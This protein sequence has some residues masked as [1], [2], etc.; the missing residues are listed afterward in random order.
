MDTEM[1]QAREN[2]METIQA[3]LKEYDHIPPEEKCM[4][5]LLAEERFL[6]IKQ[7][8]EEEQNQPE[9]MQEL[10]LKL[11]KDL[12]ILNGIQTK[13]E[14]LAEQEEPAVPKSKTLCLNDNSSAIFESMPLRI[15]FLNFFNDPKIIREQRNA[16]YKG[17]RGGVTMTKVIKGEFEKLESLKISDVSLTC[18]TSL[19]IF[20]KEFNRMSRMDD[21]LFTYEVEIAKTMDHYT[22]KELWMYWARGDD[23]FEI[24]DKESSTSEDEDEVAENFWIETNLFDF[25]TPLCK[26]FKKFNYLL[27]INPD[28]LTEDIEGFKT[29]KYYK[30][31]WISLK[32]GKLKEE[33]L[34]NKAIME[35]IIEYEDNESS[36]EGWRRW[37]IYEN[38]NHGPEEREYDMEH[39]NKERCELFDDQERPFPVFTAGVPVRL[40]ALAMAAVC[41]SRAAV[42][43]AV[44]YRMASK[45][46]AGVSDVDLIDEMNY[47][48]V[49]EEDGEWIRFLGGSS[50]SGTKK[51]QRLNS[52]DGGNTGDGVKIAGGVIGSG[53]EIEF[54]EELKV[55][56]LDATLEIIRMKTQSI[57]KNIHRGK[58]ILK[59]RSRL[60]EDIVLI[61][62]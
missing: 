29:Y 19:E 48:V 57:V 12:Q 8:V 13:Q 25:E 36:N 55:C 18:N 9:V 50:S 61:T 23:E 37:N 27:Q 62:T 32:D 3:F 53:D 1:L 21:D 59:I 10:L 16:A 40:L 17:Y 6:K 15:H 38:T 26:A 7:A 34:K 39:E 47:N 44:S 31:D 56:F 22:M 45:V 11:M 5:L 49:E 58:S 4:A 46:I 14:K 60:G 24:T 43:S 20:N 51:Y 42:K 33:A 52:S 41:A 28:V 54:F 30:D 35:G 2:L